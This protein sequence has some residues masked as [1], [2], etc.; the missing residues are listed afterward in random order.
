MTAPKLVLEN[1]HFRLERLADGVFAAI[2][3]LE[4]GAMSNAGI[5]DL[6]DETLVFDAFLTRAAA[7]A[8]RAAA[9]EL[10]G[11]AP[12]YL[13]NSHG[14]GDHVWGNSIFLP[15]ADVL[16][17]EGTAA[18]MTAEERSSIEPAELADVIDQLERALAEE[19]DEIVRFNYEGNLYPRKWLL[20][21]LPLDLAPPTVMLE[22]SREIRGSRRTVRLVVVDR[23]HTE[24]DVYLL[25][26]DDRVVFLGDLG[27]F[28]DL[29]A[30]IAPEGDAAAWADVLREFEALA[31]DSFVPGHGDIGGVPELADQRGFL[32]AA[33]EAAREA[34]AVSGTV[35]DVVA[36]MRETEYAKWEKTTLY[37]ASL[38][39]VLQ[40]TVEGA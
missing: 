38:E 21:E 9:E 24:G 4:G 14:H 23:A 22:G 35:D 13:V 11:R 36:R 26:P 2:A 37:R 30:Y 27:F 15:E 31:V 17:S 33:I 19:T 3:T 6:G 16:A 32:D 18:M 7:K 25:C 1:E 34:A 20:E 8:L 10:T 5:V 28:K 39:A 12:R 29:P 40:K